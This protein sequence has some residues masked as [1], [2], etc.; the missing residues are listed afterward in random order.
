[1]GCRDS[2]T[3]GR[4]CRKGKHATSPHPSRTL[5]DRAGDV[6]HLENCLSLAS[7]LLCRMHILVS[8]EPISR[9]PPGKAK[10]AQMRNGGMSRIPRPN[11]A[12]SHHATAEPKTP[13][14]ELLTVH[15]CIYTN[16]RVNLSHVVGL[17]ITRTEV[18][19]TLIICHVSYSEILRTICLSQKSRLV[20]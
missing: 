11:T 10:E 2:N 12:R 16:T 14:L 9:V 1:M 18:T 19:L 4:L 20:T 15:V 6:P 17:H 5:W 8:A 13:P 3:T 7:M